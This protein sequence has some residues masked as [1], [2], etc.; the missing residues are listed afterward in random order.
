MLA[1]FTQHFQLP[2]SALK[3]MTPGSSDYLRFY[4]N[5]SLSYAVSVHDEL[6]YLNNVNPNGPPTNRR[7]FN[8][9]TADHYLTLTMTEHLKLNLARDPCRQD[10]NYSFILCV[11][12]SLAR[13][14]RNCPCC[15]NLKPVVNRTFFKTRVFAALQAAGHQCMSRR[16]GS[17]GIWGLRIWWHWH[18]ARIISSQEIYDLYGRKHHIVEMRVGVTDAGQTTKP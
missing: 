18:V 1:N 2:H 13:Q 12:E 11:R 9:S 10:F 16:Q 14:V 7:T 3:S 6:F 4:L 17:H 5:S 15:F 8:G